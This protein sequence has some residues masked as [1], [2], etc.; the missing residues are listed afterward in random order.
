MPDPTL[1][2]RLAAIGAFA[3]EL[4]APGFTAGAWHPSAPTRDDPTVWTMPW[5][6]LTPRATAFVR[7]LAA[8]MITFDWP[9][10]AATDEAQALYRDR[11]ALANATP[12]ELAR[13]V[14]AVVRED[15]FNEGALGD[16]FEAGVMA[17]IARRAAALANADG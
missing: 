3:D 13:L 17:A 11:A 16:S 15:R 5:Y 12:D 7:A 1:R 14:T 4:E 9:T 8:I 6:E 2:E 10:W